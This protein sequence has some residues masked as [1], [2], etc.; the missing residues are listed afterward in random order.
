MDC[1]TETLDVHE[2]SSAQVK[3]LQAMLRQV[4]DGRCKRGRRYEAATVLVLLVLA[5]LAGETTVSGAA[6][7][8]HLRA[9]WLKAAL[10]IERLPCANTYVYVCAHL[11]VT[12]LNDCLKAWLQQL[13]PPHT[14]EPLQQWALDGK[15]L[16][17]S[18]RHTPVGQ[19]AQEVLNVYAVESGRLEHCQ[20][21]ERKG[22]AAAAAQA[23]VEQRD[24]RGV[25]ITA[26][27]L[28]T[29]PALCR[30]IRQQQ[31]HYVLL[32][33]RNRPLLEAE[34]R[35]L[36]A[37]PPHPDFPV[38]RITTTERGH[39]RQTTRQLSTSSEL[40]LALQHEWRDVAQV[41]V[42]ERHGHRQGQPY[43]DSVCG[44]T[45]LPPDQATPAHLLAWVQAH[46][47]IENRCHWRRDATLGEDACTVRHPLV[48]AILAVLNSAIL[49]LFDH[50]QVTNARAAIRRFAAAPDQALALLI[51][52]L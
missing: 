25:V 20:R 1:T 2:L 9:G 29:R 14:P 23:F 10:G 12:Q 38:A 40:N 37:L 13:A 19:H 28:H 31:G 43:R 51:Q 46:W 52:P 4:P 39:G 24:C 34:I 44:L 42:L 30:T 6:Q 36:F 22:Y 17:G 7:W 45:S 33:K 21:I 32:V 35:W 15:V 49:A 3:S 47:H 5:K 27:A 41:F 50:L 48:A 26:D 8:V 18:R 16:C 11:D